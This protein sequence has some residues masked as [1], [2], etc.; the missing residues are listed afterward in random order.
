MK[1]NLCEQIND[2][3]NNSEKINKISKNGKKRYFEIF[4]NSISI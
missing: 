2:I 1:K 3:K 4:N